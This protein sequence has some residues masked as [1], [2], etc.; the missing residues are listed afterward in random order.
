[1]EYVIP[2]YLI[3]FATLGLYSL[4]LLKRGRDL[5]KQLPEEERR[6]LD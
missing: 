1:M 3:A 6:F 4:Q 2:G 5:S